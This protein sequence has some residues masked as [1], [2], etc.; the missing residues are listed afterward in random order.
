MRAHTGGGAAATSGGRRPG[1][2]GPRSIGRWGASVL[3]L[4]IAFFGGLGAPAHAQ[5]TEPLRLTLDEAIAFAEGSNPALRQ[6]TNTAQLNGVE[7]RTTWTDQLL[8]SAQL[9][10]FQTGFT[11]NLQR[12]SL[13]NFGNPIANPQA[14]WNYFSST[15]HALSLSWSFQG[16]S[17]LQAHRAQTLTNRERDLARRVA[18]TDVQIEVQRR[19]VDALEQRELLR[20]EEELIGARRIDL[21][22]A[23]RLFGLALR[24]RVDVLNAELA[25]EQQT[26]V[27]QQRE[28]AYQRALLALGSSMGRA[29]DRP[30]DVV[31][32]DLPVFDP[33]GLSADALVSRALEA[34]PSLLRSDVA[35]RSAEVAVAQRRSA[36]WPRVSMGV[37]VYRRAYEQYTDALFDASLTSDLESQFFIRLSLPILGNYFQEDLQRQQASVDLSNRREADRQAR[38]ELEEAIR[39]SLLDLENE[40]TS[41]RLSE[42]SLVIAEEAL[43]LAREEYRLGTRSFEDLRS[44]FEQEAETRR[45]VITARHSFVD[46]LLTLEEAVGAP[47]RDVATPGGGPAPEADEGALGEGA[48]P[49]GAATRGGSGAA[50]GARER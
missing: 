43:R 23:E 31:D 42:R 39:G 17:L 26:L 33:A 36:W 20:A 46:A 45:Q 27:A 34:N 7:S 13:D 15:N 9:T 37:D 48:G 40:W 11:G 2:H 21:D 10:L 3:P 25:V 44:S 29:D 4:A 18:L 32:V 49:D 30:I 14:E 6:A 38:L 22:V 24:T 5:D 19:Y 16:L 47:V 35:I 28:A 1:G 12:R 50:Q 8:P 41:L